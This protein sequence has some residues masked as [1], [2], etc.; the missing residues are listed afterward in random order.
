[1]DLATGT[2]PA[3]PCECPP[4]ATSGRSSLAHITVPG[5]AENPRGLA[6]NPETPHADA[7][8]LGRNRV[9]LSQEGILKD[10]FPSSSRQ[11]AHIG[12]QQ[13][14][15]SIAVDDPVYAVDHRLLAHP[16][17]PIVLGHRLVN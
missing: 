2:L 10:G 7:W 15:Q 17:A 4:G 14:V 8:C 13:I 11:Y 16:D 1:M 9:E 6:A 12:F 5:R 3:P